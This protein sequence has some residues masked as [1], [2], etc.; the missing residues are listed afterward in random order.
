M[1][2]QAALNACEATVRQSDPDRYFAS[3]FA[4]EE[5]RP[6][7]FVL[8]AF[9]HELARIGETVKEPMV[10][11]IRLQWWREALASAR[12]LHHRGH[13]V[14]HGLVDVFARVGPPLELFEAMIDAR[15][16]DAAD[17][18]FADMESLEAYADATSGNLMRLATRVLGAG[19]ERETLH[20]AHARAAGIAYALT[21]ILRAIPFHAAHG[22]L[23]LPRDV[24]ADEG[25]TPDDVL[26]HHRGG[27][28]KPVIARIAARAR[29]HLDAS[30]LM[31]R[32]GPALAAFLP[33]AIAPLYL[34]QM[35]QPGFDVFHDAVAPALFRRQ[36]GLLRG[37]WRG[38]V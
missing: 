22:K 20:D 15:E 13:D 33:A 8:Y 30:R 12:D 17:V 29:V 34:K 18:T 14:V 35:E 37:V 36:W 24:L 7:L 2:L 4:P 6:L 11:A 27:R 23:F 31:E 26:V 1:D 38:R 16:S 21:G 10:A 19:E 5:R 3:L 28:L 32:P 9:N 25:V